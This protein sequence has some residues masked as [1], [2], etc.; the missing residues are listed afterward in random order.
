MNNTSDRGSNNKSGY[1]R[2]DDLIKG[3][4]TRSDGKGSAEE[5]K[6]EDKNADPA[7]GNRGQGNYSNE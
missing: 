2:N 7:A 4:N 5:I 1:N 6:K 3:Q